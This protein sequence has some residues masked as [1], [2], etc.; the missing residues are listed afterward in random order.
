METNIHNF[1]L[2]ENEVEKLTVLSETTDLPE[3]PVPQ[4]PNGPWAALAFTAIAASLTLLLFFRH[5]S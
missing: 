1:P 3:G 5:R 2:P 4:S